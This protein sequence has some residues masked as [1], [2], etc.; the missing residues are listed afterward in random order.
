[1][2]R[3][4]YFGI[5]TE[6]NKDWVGRIQLSLKSRLHCS[7]SF[8]VNKS[9]L[10]VGCIFFVMDIEMKSKSKLHDEVCCSVC[11]LTFTDP[12]QLPC[13]HSF[14]LH[15]LNGLVRT[16]DFNGPF[17]TCPQCNKRLKIPG[18]GSPSELPS[19]LRINSLLNILAI[20]ECKTKT[21]E[22]KVKC[23]NCDKR[24]DKTSYCFQCYSFWCEECIIGHNII[25]AN[26]EHRTLA[27]NDFQDQDIEDLL[28][29]P[30]FCHEEYHEKEQ[31]K[32]FCK[33]CEV[34]I[35]N[36][37]V[38]TLHDNHSK[39]LVQEAK[40]ARKTK[41]NSVIKSLNETAQDGRRE[42]EKFDLKSAEIQM[43]V[44]DVKG[45]VQTK[46]DQIIATIEARKQDILNAVRSQAS[47]SLEPLTK[48]KAEV[49]NR[50]KK[51]DSAIEQT[52]FL[53]KQNFSTEILG[54]NETFHTILNEDNTQA[55]SDSEFIPLLSFSKNENLKSVLNSEGIG[56]LKTVLAKLNR[57]FRPLLSF[58]QKG[59]SV[60]M[61]HFP[62][63][64]A[65]NNHDEIAVSECGNH[66]ITI[67][68]REGTFLKSFG[69]RGKSNGMFINPSGIAFDQN[70]NVFVV[71]SFNHRVQVFD[72]NGNFLRKFGEQG[73]LDH[74]LEHPNGLSINGSGDLIVSDSANKFI[75]I[76]SPNGKFLRKFGGAASLVTPF[77]CIQHGQFFIVSDWSDHSFKM[78]DLEGNCISKYG[79]QGK[80]DGEF[81]DPR[82]FS[83]DKEGLLMICDGCSHRVQ[84]FEL[85]GKFVTKF[86]SKGSE[87]GEFKFP[88]S[89]ANLSDGRVVVCD[90]WN[91]RIQIFDKI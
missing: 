85:N 27:L 35:C 71:D 26:K 16:S 61:L 40:N 80:G 76:F 59:K 49:E 70:N 58:G 34:A 10:T 74:Q 90:S 72:R 38:L 2:K 21:A 41:I 62:W 7:F 9:T 50:V 15:C 42:A 46:V 19:N 63:G 13:L 48:K 28:R 53:M 18:S 3:I 81:F 29:R 51:L 57:T 79:K 4:V 23:E 44:A 86:G 91:H 11:L 87:R 78:F 14:C 77:H 65:V 69:R 1:M 66:R 20:K 88:N 8:E 55:N 52:E 54:F 32:F 45:K 56:D 82:H 12:K 73:S 83:V 47:I 39:M 64:V 68:S 36:T 75:K 17:L 89:T 30:A 60:G 5:H 67:F 33:D 22:V 25:R 31:M 6:K 37:C 43:K 24:S 84:V